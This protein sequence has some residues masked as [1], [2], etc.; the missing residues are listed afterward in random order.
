[1]GSTKPLPGETGIDPARASLAVGR[2]S[3]GLEEHRVEEEHRVDLEAK[4]KAQSPGQAELEYSRNELLD[5]YDNAPIGYVTLDCV[6]SIGRL[7]VAAAR[8]SPIRS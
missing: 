4:S 1:M 8:M 3:A 2:L 6:G 5:L 7:N